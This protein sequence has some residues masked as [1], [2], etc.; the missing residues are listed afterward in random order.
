MAGSRVRSAD[1]FMERFA[2]HV[3]GLHD[4]ATALVEGVAFAVESLVGDQQINH[5]LNARVNSSPALPFS[6]ELASAFGRSMM[7]RYD[8]DWGRYGYGDAELNEVGELCMRTFHSLVVDPG[9]YIEDGMLLRRFIFG[10]LAPAIHYR[11]MTRTIETLETIAATK[12]VCRSGE[13]A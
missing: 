12:P 13:S 2:E 4:P 11:S 10:W 6:S 1:G 5:V 9:G 3:R 7:R 8:V